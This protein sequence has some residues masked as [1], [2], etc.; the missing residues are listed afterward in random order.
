MLLVLPVL[1]YLVA[2]HPVL[3][4]WCVGGETG[5]DSCWQHRKDSKHNLSCIP[6]LHQELQ[7]QGGVSDE[8]PPLSMPQH[9]VKLHP[10]QV[11]GLDA[12][13]HGMDTGSRGT[14]LHP[15][16]ASKSATLLHCVSAGL[17]QHR[18]DGA[19]LHPR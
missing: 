7:E 9:T 2:V 18:D 16:S 3:P 19:V 11:S 17:L 1:Q 14:W 13:M 5:T 8:W 15:A 10:L 4:C 12:H 6:K